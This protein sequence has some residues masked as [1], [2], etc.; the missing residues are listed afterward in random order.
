MRR[1]R[2]LHDQRALG[3]C[4]CVHAGCL[5]IVPS[6]DKA[7]LNALTQAASMSAMLDEV[8]A[9][10]VIKQLGVNQKL[11]LTQATH[12]RVAEIAGVK[13][14]AAQVQ[15]R[16]ARSDLSKTLGTQ[17]REA[18]L[19][20][21]LHAKL[22]ADMRLRLA[23]LASQPPSWESVVE[24]ADLLAPVERADLEDIYDTASDE[25]CEFETDASDEAASALSPI[26][27]AIAVVYARVVVA[28]TMVMLLHWTDFEISQKGQAILDLA[29]ELLSLVPARDQEGEQE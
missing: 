29:L 12:K 20:S 1:I 7:T 4:N 24:T 8:G 2:A 27:L 14:L 11:G 26:S 25:L 6:V 5:S 9:R 17:M 28:A 16:F 3:N 23:D 21:E 10:E 18:L 13:E 19:Q 15:E 22:T